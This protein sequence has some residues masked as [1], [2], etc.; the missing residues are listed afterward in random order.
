MQLV[1]DAKQVNKNY[2]EN[3]DS[4]LPIYLAALDE[5]RYC[6]TEMELLLRAPKSVSIELR[7]LKKKATSP[8]ISL[9]KKKLRFELS[10]SLHVSSIHLLFVVADLLVVYLKCGCPHCQSI[11]PECFYLDLCQSLNLCLI[12]KKMALLLNTTKKMV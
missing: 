3:R 5:N 2:L 10:T 4:A 9:T 12:L 7:K 11:V 6:Q 8:Q 1:T